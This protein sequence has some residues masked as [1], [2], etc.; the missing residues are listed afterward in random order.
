[1]TPHGPGVLVAAGMVAA[2]IENGFRCDECGRI[3]VGSLETREQ[4]GGGYSDA[5]MEIFWKNRVPDT[6]APAYVEGQDFPDVPPHIGDAAG[7]AHKSMS[8]GNL[9]S[10]ILMARTVVEA[11]AKNKGITSG[12]L[13]NKI[14]KL[15]EKNFIREFTK[16]TAHAIRGFGNDMAHGDIEL[17][18]D[19]DDAEMVLDFMGALL[20]EVFQNPAKLAALQA[21]IEAR[22]QS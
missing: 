10:A 1:M 4:P 5:S 15:A 13:F 16:E 12:N 17:P 2:K 20:I 14:D 9:K 6:W 22:K 18:V 3:S 19:H 21:K 11:T 7:E 8:I